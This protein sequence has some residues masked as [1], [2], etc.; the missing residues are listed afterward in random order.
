VA[1]V[2][3]S[4]GVTAGARE[5]EDVFRAIGA[6]EIVELIGGITI[7]A[8]PFKGDEA[9]QLKGMSVYEQREARRLGA[10]HERRGWEDFVYIPNNAERGVAVLERILKQYPP[11]GA[12]PAISAEAE[13]AA[14]ASAATATE[15]THGEGTD[16][17]P[18][19]A[20]MA[21]PA[22]RDQAGT[23]G[24][25]QPAHAATPAGA[26]RRSVVTAR[27]LE[28]SLEALRALRVEVEQQVREIAGGLALEAV[29]ERDP[30]VERDEARPQPGP[31]TPFV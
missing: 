12:G 6:G 22:A 18:E 7:Q 19:P 20:A 1:R 5:P 25:T 10:L 28:P 2:L 13:I 24:A 27:D 8:V 9:Y 15:P 11:V 23:Y 4:I 14:K 30:S 17:A 16:R 21:G 3:R 26:D 31:L 29:E